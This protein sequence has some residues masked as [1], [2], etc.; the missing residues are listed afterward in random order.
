M[1]WLI[2]FIFS[3]IMTIAAASNMG[4]ASLAAEKSTQMLVFGF[5]VIFDVI[6]WCKYNKYKSR[7]NAEKKRQKAEKKK[8]EKNTIFVAKHQ[9]GLA[10]AQDV[11][12]RILLEPD[13]YKISGSGNIFQLSKSKITDVAVRSDYEIQKQYVSSIGGAIAGKAV[14]GTLGAIV[15]GR[16]KEKRSVTTTY[17]LIFT[18][19]SE[20]DINYVSFEVVGSDLRK[21]I[22]WAKEAR[23]TGNHESQVI[24]L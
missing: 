5:F 4:D 23:E 6:F 17:Y 19:R 12:C 16:A 8:Q 14:F 3:V 18:Y 10:L 7:T 24:E 13:S 20:E 1:G 21:A 22:R 11:V 2:G 15:G 9:A